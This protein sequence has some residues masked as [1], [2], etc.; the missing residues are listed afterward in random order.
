SEAADHP[1]ELTRDHLRLRDQLIALEPSARPADTTRALSRAAQLLAASS[2]TH[3]TVFLLSLQQRTG[4]RTD[5]APWGKDGPQL[6]VVDLRPAKMA[7]FAITALHFDP[8]PGTGSRGVR[9]D[10]EVGNF[11]DAAASMELQLSIGDRVVAR[12]TLELP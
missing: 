6:V 11:S 3:K 12:G 7:N 1:S 8:D 9:F 2:H 4:L 10:A 5:E